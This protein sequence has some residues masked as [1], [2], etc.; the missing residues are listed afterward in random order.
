MFLLLFGG[1][2]IALIRLRSLRPDF[3]R[4]YRVPFVPF[5][6]ILAVAAMLFIAVF[7][8]VGYP[9]AWLAAGGWIAAGLI[10]YR[11]YSR[12]RERAYS[13]RVDWMERLER[14]EYRVLVA[15]ANPGLFETMMSIAV[16]IAKKYSGN[17][18]VTSVVEVPDGESLFSGRKRTREL[19]PMLER[20]VA[21]AGEHGVH[22][23]SLVKIGRRTSESLV[24]TAHEESC[25]LLVLGPPRGTTFLERLVSSIGERV[26]Q[27]APCQVAVVYGS[28]ARG[29]LSGVVTP[30]TAGS[31]SRLAAEL[32][33]AMCEWLKLPARFVT[34]VPDDV[35]ETD[36]RAAVE[37]AQDTAAASGLPAQVD[38]LR[39]ADAGRGLLAGLRPDEVVLVGAPSVGPISPLLG[40]T[41]PGVLATHHSGPV[42]I[43]RN[44]ES[45]PRRF[46]RFF[47]GE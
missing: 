20:C 42:L 13:E 8:F 14:R 29:A 25:N 6:P 22:A 4:G 40:E 46:R 43:V 38:V 17:I 44:V 2:N 37:I 21:F 10:F 11:V 47:F 36:S 23:T 28:L 41:V 33:P 7:M 3:D 1:V 26:L 27:N 12:S 45:H 30:V 5:T 32:V 16:A 31:N 18:V 39:G 9:L 34:I 19:E 24:Q 15:I 35:D